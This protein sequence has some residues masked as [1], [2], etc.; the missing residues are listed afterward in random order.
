[1]PIE[2]LAMLAL[3]AVMSASSVKSNLVLPRCELPDSYQFATNTCSVELKN[4]GDKPIRILSTA[5]T[6]PG[7]TIQA[8]P[9]VVPPHASA[10]LDAH[11]AWK[12][13]SGR[14]L[15]IFHLTTD[16]PGQ[17]QRS[18]EVAGYVATALDEPK[19][20]LDFGVVDLPGASAEKSVTLAS[21]EVADFAIERILSMPDY[22]S[23]RIGDDHRTL[24]ASIKPDAPW[25]L[26]EDAFVKVKINTPNQSE[27]WIAVHVDVHGEVI[28]DTN[29]LALGL[30]RKGNKNEF[31]IRL[32]SRDGKDFDVGKVTP[33]RL[34][35]QS[36]V[37]PCVPERSG[38][39]LVRF[40]LADD[41]QTGALS[42]TLSIELPGFKRQLP[43]VVWG[44][45][46]GAKTKVRNLAEEMEKA[47]AAKA[48]SGMGAESPSANPTVD[49]GQAI[50]SS[51]AETTPEAPPAGKG[52]LLKW[53]VVHEELIHG[54]AIYRAEKQDG[55]FVRINKETIATKSTEGAA[56]YQW[57][58][59]SASSGKTYWYYVGLLNRD[60]TK[61]ILT[62]PQ[63]VVA[64]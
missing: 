23:A 34:H 25:G 6:T 38:C 57:R 15:R 46:V 41:Q 3:H 58:D 26:H 29:P 44:M 24:T 48:K 39:K 53:S 22:L 59:N 61:A 60:G 10:Y 63:R 17:E 32:T 43:V 5:A 19:A 14:G 33:G 1:M 50:K 64:K 13:E 49:L 31:L 54:Y 4:T 35:G 2:S 40:V 55:P 47:A 18:A 37:E 30:L 36:S 11:V 42:D 45:L 12:N 62:P 8:G 51:V 56:S 21:R 27:A 52:P 9:L 7:D 28:P 20:L 16:E